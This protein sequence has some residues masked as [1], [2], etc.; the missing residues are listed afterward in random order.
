MFITTD[1][2]V[3]AHELGQSKTVAD[4]KLELSNKTKV[5]IEELFLI[6]QGKLL[7][8]DNSNL[9]DI[10]IDN[11]TTLHLAMRLKGGAQHNTM[12]AYCLCLCLNP[13]HRLYLGDTTGCLIHCLTGGLCFVGSVCDC[14]NMD[15]LVALAD[16]GRKLPLLATSAAIEQSKVAPVGQSM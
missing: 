8:D 3:L 6:S 14:I 4:L 13:F 5:P 11:N 9:V 16:G 7:F 12:L 15:G 2:G 1:F 10:G